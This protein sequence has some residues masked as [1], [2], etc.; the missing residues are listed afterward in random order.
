MCGTFYKDVAP[1]ALGNGE[2]VFGRKPL[3]IRSGVVATLSG[4]PPESQTDDT[5]RGDGKAKNSLLENSCERLN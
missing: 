2:T 1:L 5:I 4:M 3:N